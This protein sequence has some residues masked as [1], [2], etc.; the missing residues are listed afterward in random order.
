MMA[1]MTAHTK[2]EMYQHIPRRMHEAQHPPEVLELLE[3]EYG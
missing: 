1:A 3:L 2:A